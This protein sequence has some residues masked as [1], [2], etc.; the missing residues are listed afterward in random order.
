[1]VPV[2]ATV[3]GIVARAC[4]VSQQRQRRQH[5]NEQINHDSVSIRLDITEKQAAEQ[6]QEQ[7]QLQ[8]Q[9]QQQQQQHWLQQHLHHE[10]CLTT[11]DTTAANA[12]STSTARRSASDQPLPAYLQ[13]QHWRQQQLNQLQEQQWQQQKHWFQSQTAPNGDHQQRRKPV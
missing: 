13:Q 2:E 6:E 12:T 4:Q 5:K 7:L 10:S 11:Y 1:M 3:A 9:L 8:Q